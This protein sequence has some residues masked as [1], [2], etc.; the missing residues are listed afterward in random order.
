MIIF[1]PRYI[2]PTNKAADLSEYTYIV[3]DGDIGEMVNWLIEMAGIEVYI[4]IYKYL[5]YR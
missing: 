5:I 4:N 3:E 2:D 1:Y